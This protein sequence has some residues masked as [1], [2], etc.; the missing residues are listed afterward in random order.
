MKKLLLFAAAFLC[1]EAYMEAQNQSPRIL[2]AY[3]SWSGNTRGIAEQIHRRTGGDLFE[4]E[5]AVPYSRNYNTALEEA[6][7]D[8]KARARPALK[9][10][11]A[12]M[13]S[14]DVILL[15]YPNWC[16]TIPMPIATF[17]EE[18][19]FSGKTIIPFCSY[20]GGRLGQ[21][22]ADIAKLSPRA[23][24]GDALSVRQSG[25]SSLPNDIAAWLRKNGIAER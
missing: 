15:G 9:A 16:S 24:I 2:I 12:D 4:I 22:L 21:S 19:D 23:K 20:G 10:R 17:L 8:L 13:K 25:D 11:V 3:F 18:Y 14:Y 5:C 7:R 1:M 6:R